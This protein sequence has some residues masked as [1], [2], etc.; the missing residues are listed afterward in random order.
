M[1]MVYLAVGECTAAPGSLR[2]MV[3][4]QARGIVTPSG[5]RTGCIPT[6][7]D[8]ESQRGSEGSK[9]HEGPI[10]QSI[11]EE[12]ASAHQS[13][14]VEANQTSLDVAGCLEMQLHEDCHGPRQQ[15]SPGKPCI[16]LET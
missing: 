5:R 10:L 12:A 11:W 3:G 4:A 9:E 16:Q 7:Q 2:R 6:S 8:G 14:A 15:T 1:I 13:S